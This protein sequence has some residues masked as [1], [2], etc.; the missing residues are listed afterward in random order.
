[1]RRAVWDFDLVARFRCAVASLAFRTFPFPALPQ[2]RAPGV[3]IFVTFA[4]F[5]LILLTP[6]ISL[7]PSRLGSAFFEIPFMLLGGHPI[8][9][10]VLPMPVPCTVAV[11]HPFLPPSFPPS[12]INFFSLT[13]RCSLRAS[14]SFHDPSASHLTVICPAADPWPSSSSLSHQAPSPCGQ[15][16]L[17]CSL[18]LLFYA[19]LSPLAFL[20]CRQRL[21]PRFPP[22]TA[23]SCAALTQF[24]HSPL[25][26]FLLATCCLLHAPSWRTAI[27]FTVSLLSLRFFSCFRLSVCS[28]SQSY[29]S[30]LPL[31]R[32]PLA[33]SLWGRL[34]L[35]AF[36]RLSHRAHDERF[37]RSAG[38]S[39]DA[40][41]LRRALHDRFSR[42]EIQM[43]LSLHD[44]G[45][46]AT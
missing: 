10:V 39:I 46:R 24:P 17:F 37:H 42:P 25:R 20:K 43:S 41:F 11:A 14:L 8:P 13:F 31:S 3:A 6:N 4:P 30:F 12:G 35:P 36:R 45:A 26:F 33:T 9:A 44:H 7:R 40:M 21:G 28:F 16:R 27:S 19:L 23:H 32:P 2:R 22:P 5:L 29:P 34:A 15:P 38:R 1:M 18:S